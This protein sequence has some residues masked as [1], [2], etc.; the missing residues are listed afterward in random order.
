MSIFDLT[1]I[2]AYLVP[3]RIV[4]GTAVANALL[5]DVRNGYPYGTVAATSSQKGLVPNVGSFQQSLNLQVD[6]QVDAVTSLTGEVDKML[7]TLNAGIQQ[8]GKASRP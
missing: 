1:I 6:A 7:T 3:S 5:F 4:E 2:G 8:S